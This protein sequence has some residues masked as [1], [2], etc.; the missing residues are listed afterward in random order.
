MQSHNVIFKENLF[1]HFIEF[2]NWKLFF[3]F[4]VFLCFMCTQ[5]KFFFLYYVRFDSVEICRV[6]VNINKNYWK[7]IKC[8]FFLISG[9]LF[10]EKFKCWIDFGCFNGCNRLISVRDCWEKSI[11]FGRDSCEIV[12]PLLH[13]N[14][15]VH[16]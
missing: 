4:N 11:F 10:Y 16:S 13:L 2:S 3:L 8:D 6:W 7:W 1:D 15:F 12:S 9:F 14:G 5:E